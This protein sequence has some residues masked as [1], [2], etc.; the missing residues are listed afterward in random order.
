MHHYASALGIGFADGLRLYLLALG[1]GVVAGL[2]TF[3]APAAVAW[4]AHLGRLHLHDSPFAFMGSTAAVVIFTLAA[5]FEY[6]YDLSPIARRRTEPGSLIA[7]IIS[8]GFSGACLFAA[9]SQSWIV[10]GLLG[11]IGG[12][13]GAFGGYNTRK[14]LVEGLKVKDAMIAIPEDLLAIGVAYVIA[15]S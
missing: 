14:R 9:A 2:R 1:I 7:R 8:G 5:L 10:G 3:T 4:G 13:I 12:V 6:G 11:G 15:I